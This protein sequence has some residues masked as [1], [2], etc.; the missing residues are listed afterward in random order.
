[1]PWFKGAIIQRLNNY[2]YPPHDQK[3]FNDFFLYTLSWL[4]PTFNW[5]PYW[6][7]NNDA[8]I[9]HFH[10]P[11][12]DHAKRLE[13]NHDYNMKKCYKDLYLKSNNGY[14]TYLN[15]YEYF[16]SKEQPT[17]SVTDF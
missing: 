17:R 6:G 11:K 14:N 15:L 9:V 1:M 4:N 10:G 8:V 13:V 16:L 12:Y 7:V 2:Q 5:K 3:S